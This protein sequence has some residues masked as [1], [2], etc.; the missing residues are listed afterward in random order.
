M[1]ATIRALNQDGLT[2]LLIEQNA[3]QALDVTTRAYVIEQ[4]RIVHSGPSTQLAN[5][6]GIVAH[7]LGQTSGA[8]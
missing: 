5:D 3:K 1:F 2:I 4:G 7:Y 6:P 8:D